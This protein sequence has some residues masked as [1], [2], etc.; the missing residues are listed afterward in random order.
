MSAL[1]LKYALWCKSKEAYYQETINNYKLVDERYGIQ[2]VTNNF[3][4]MFK[5]VDNENN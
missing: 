2:A 1:E 3:I 5:V 4:E